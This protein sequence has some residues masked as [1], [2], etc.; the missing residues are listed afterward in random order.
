MRHTSVRDSILLVNH[1]PDTETSLKRLLGGVFEVK[2]WRTSQSFEGLFGGDSLKLIIYEFNELNDKSFEF[3]QALRQYEVLK[4]VPI[5][6]LIDAEHVDLMADGFYKGIADYLIKPLIPAEV[7]VRVGGQLELAAT[8]VA[9]SE[10]RVNQMLN[11]ASMDDQV[12]QARPKLLLVDDY[13]S[14]LQALTEILA[15]TYDVEI[16]DNGREALRL[17]AQNRFDLILLDIVMPE[18]D[19]YEVCR[20]LKQNDSTCDIPVIFLTAQFETRDEIYGLELGAVDYIFKPYNL[21]VL[22]ARIKIHLDAA[23]HQQQLKTSSYL[24]GLTNIPN[25]RFFDECC[26]RELKLA[27]RDHKPLAILLV[28]VDQFKKYNDHYGHPAGDQ[29]LI[30]V[31]QALLSCERRPSD[32]IGRYG[33]EEF[34][35]VLPD[36]SAEGAMHVANAMVAKVEALAMAQAP[37]ARHASVTISLGGVHCHVAADTRIEDL[38]AI[39]DKALYRVKGQGGNAVNFESLDALTHSPA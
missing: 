9:L 2:T 24:D 17:V 1:T 35:A 39:A 18:L 4:R 22:Q 14:N 34:V 36:T 31:A 13:V 5:V 19:G 12:Q 28:D 29:C 30:E 6:L 15:E 27:L 21:A 16:A 20:Q 10:M 8:E 11:P 26:D 7:L 3:C 23:R 33:G 38:L 25:R 32:F 37:D